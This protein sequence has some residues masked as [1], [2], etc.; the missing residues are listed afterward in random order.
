MC[1]RTLWVS[2][3]QSQRL[4]GGRRYLGQQQLYRT[5]VTHVP[6][7]NHWLFATGH[8]M[9]PLHLTDTAD[10]PRIFQRIHSPWNSGAQT[11]QKSRS[12]LKIPAARQRGGMKHVPPWRPTNIKRHGIKSRRPGFVYPYFR[13]IHSF[14]ILSDDR[15][16]ASSKTMPPYSAIQRLLLQMRISSPVLKVIQ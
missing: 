9:P 16:K 10:S 6:S 12:H 3:A 15:S 1:Y 4:L 11:L 8:V 2:F 14:S 7:L 5:A 13:F